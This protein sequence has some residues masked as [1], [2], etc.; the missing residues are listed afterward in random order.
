MSQPIAMA[1]PTRLDQRVRYVT[2][3]DGLRLAWA[4][5]GEGPMIVK[6]ANWLTHL[7]YERDSP[8]WRHWLQFFSSLG[9]FVRHDERGCG[10][11]DWRPGT[12]SLDQ[13]TSD[14]A[15][16]VDAAEPDGPITLLG[17]SQ[18]AATCIAYAARHPE[19]V[20]R[21]ILYGG[22]ARGAALRGTSESQRAFRAMTDLIRVS[23]GSH[24]ET[25]R[26]VF[27][28]RFIPDGTRAQLDWFND[29]CLRTAPGD[30]VASLFDARAVVDVSSLMAQV[31]V[32]TLVLHARG[33]EVIPIEEGR[34]LASG[35]PHAEFVEL[36]SR[37]HILLEH[38]PAWDRF[39]EAVRS[40]G[41]GE[42]A[43]TRRA[44]VAEPF[45]AL[46]ARERQVLA[47]MT[48]GL[49]NAAIAERLGISDKTVRNHASH[50]FDKLGV[51]SRAQAIVFAR[52]HGFE[53]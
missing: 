26:Q 43:G 53:P 28:S 35:I 7:E 42:G 52:D 22:Y 27:T 50:V 13:W 24:N 11:S 41:A 18:G 34:I 39:R 9:R 2:T 16:V 38:E 49:G 31:R 36:D 45:A 44:P 32:P 51:W 14:L 46:S 4:A 19:R 12:L 5:S 25:F 33:D 30:V 3:G 10:M 1:R 21:L 17:I 47:A 37:N 20:G 40:F 48:D 6:A 15:T 23:W 29:L 8:V